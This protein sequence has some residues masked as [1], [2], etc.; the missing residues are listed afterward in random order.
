M[1][2][3][4]AIVAIGRADKKQMVVVCDQDSKVLAR[5]I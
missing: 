5:R 4:H 3:D 1:P 2:V